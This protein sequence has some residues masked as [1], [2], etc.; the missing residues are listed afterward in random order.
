MIIA[1]QIELLGGGVVSQI[2]ECAGAMFHLGPG[3]DGGA[4]DPDIDFTA[5]LASDGEIPIGRRASNR[6]FTLP[7]VIEAMNRIQLIAAREVLMRTI[8][9]PTWSL[10]WTRDGSNLPSMFDCFR[11]GQATVTRSLPL[12]TYAVACLVTITFPALPYARNDVPQVV[13][14]TSPIA[15]VAAQASA[16]TLDS[17]SS[18]SGSYWSQSTTCAI[19]PNTAFWNPYTPPGPWQ[20]E[21]TGNGTTANPGI[22]SQ[23]ITGVVA[24]RQYQA[25]AWFYSQQGWA[26]CQVLIEWYNSSG[27]LLST[28]SGPEV[29]VPA[30]VPTYITSGTFTA[31]TSTTQAKI[32]KQMVGTPANTVTMYAA[33]GPAESCYLSQ[34]PITWSAQNSATVTSLATWANNSQIG[35]GAGLACT[36]SNQSIGPVD[37]TGLTAFT[38]WVGFASQLYYTTWCKGGG[39]VVF[40]ITLTD[41]T[42]ATLSF[43]LTQKETGSLNIGIPLW[44]KIRIPLPLSTNAISGFDYTSVVGYQI[45]MSNR[46]TN[47]MQFVQVFLDTVMVAPPT[48]PL[49]SPQR[50]VVYELAGVAGSARSTFSIQCQ[51]PSTTTYSLTRYFTTPGSGKWPCPPGVTTVAVFEIAG[52]GGGATGSGGGSPEAGGGGGGA[53]SAANSSIGV[54]AGNFYNYTVGTP[55]KSPATSGGTIV[56]GGNTSFS[57]DSVTL[58]ANGGKSVSFQS[59][60][61]AN[62]GAA[63]PGGYAGGKGGNGATS[64]AGGGGGGASGGSAAAGGAGGNNS[65]D[66]GGAAG[67]AVTGGGPGGKGGTYP[68][69]S[70]SNS[71]GA[72]ATGY[73]GGSGGGSA[74]SG[75]T[76]IPGSGGMIMMTYIVTGEMATLIV[77]RPGVDAPPSLCPFVSPNIY[78]TPNGG[79]QYLVNSMI[80]SVSARFGS[81]YTIVAVAYAWNAPTTSRNISVTVSQWSP[82]VDSAAPISTQTVGP[83]AVIPSNLASNIVL[84]GELTLP[85][86]EL[87]ADNVDVYYTVSITDSNTSDQFMDIL[88]LDTMGSTV[89]LQ[90]SNDY[91]NF[92]IDE[93]GS[94]RDVGYVM[95]SMSDRTGAIS[96]LDQAIVTGGPLSLDP[97]GNPLLLVYAVEGAPSAEITYYPRWYEDRLS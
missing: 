33:A 57:G 78:D 13:D 25:A 60:T 45:T 3:W 54:T 93:P 74:G 81:T 77:H 1:E 97:Y 49:P 89:I 17:F 87:P 90:C 26:N 35:S 84:L 56:N 16:V 11:A 40:S 21:F 94:L 95:G 86:K 96:V 69:G 80:P 9:K 88:F 46:G 7:I 4:P 68:P 5:N 8:D 38:F 6:T 28:S 53:G 51:Q 58:T 30:S 92:F 42:G 14:F 71:G 85:S 19:G 52:G 66:T 24:H 75:E 70:G 2:P 37:F 65:G 15:G 32:V 67:A 62:G 83:L 73:G 10:R 18:V 61:G 63:G 47:D 34:P 27:T 91:T 20:V 43:S 48:T 79:T 76:P 39:P 29:Q 44:T 50:G 82:S 36:Y 64:I 22:I 12:E 31:P 23:M 41:S 72:P 55:G 59:P